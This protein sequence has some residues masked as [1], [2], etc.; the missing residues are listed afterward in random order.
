MGF[1]GHCSVCSQERGF[2]GEDV[3]FVE[4]VA[5][6]VCCLTVAAVCMITSSFVETRDAGSAGWTA[7]LAAGATA[8]VSGVRFGG[9]VVPCADWRC[10][11]HRLL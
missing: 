1:V 4:E 3:D 5:C 7:A 10:R 11:G 6:A 8:V 2:E 9:E